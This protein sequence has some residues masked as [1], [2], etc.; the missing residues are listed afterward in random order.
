MGGREG[1]EAGGMNVREVGEIGGRE[2]MEVGRN[3]WK[4]RSRWEK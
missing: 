3:G 2:G 4:R 1:R